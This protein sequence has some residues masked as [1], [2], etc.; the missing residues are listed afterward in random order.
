MYNITH[1]GVFKVLETWNVVVPLYGN[2]GNKFDKEVVDNILQEILLNYPGLSVSNI[3]G[4]WKGSEKTY[5]DQNYQVLID[6]IPDSTQDSTIFFANLK[7]DLQEKLCQEKIYITKESSKQEFLSFNEFFADVG[8][9]AKSEDLQKEAEQ[10]VKQLINNIDFLLQRLSYETTTLKR[11]LH[12][13]KII[14]ERRICGVKLKSEFDDIIPANIK[15]VA[16]DQIY[17][18]GE[19]LATGEDFVIIGNYELLE[20]ILEKRSHRYLIEAKNFSSSEVTT[21][22]TSPYSEAL[23]V[24]RFIEEFTMSIFNNYLLLRDEGFLSEEIK[25]TVGSDGSS[26]F[27][28]SDRGKFLL[29]CPATIPEQVVQIDILRCLREVLHLS[30]NNALDSIAVLQTKAKN[31]YTLKRAAIRYVLRNLND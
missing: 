14:W 2:D 15:I 30:E 24:K 10:V 22:F 23:S 6:T 26:Q 1:N 12:R 27:A 19:V 29:L 18:L 11:D 25:I 7:Q 13:R 28:E 31:N 8:I 17:D 16:A 21:Q 5:V 4:Y 3:I 20:F 9:Q